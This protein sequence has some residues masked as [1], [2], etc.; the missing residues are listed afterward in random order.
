MGISLTIPV[1]RKAS[2]DSRDVAAKVRAPNRGGPL[3]EG[4]T[5]AIEEAFG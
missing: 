4:H 5:R 2:E 3:P 1:C